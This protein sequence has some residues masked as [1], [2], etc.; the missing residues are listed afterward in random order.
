M[1]CIENEK[2]RGY[3]DSVKFE[4]GSGAMIYIPY[5]IDWFR[6]SKD[7]QTHQA[8]LRFSQKFGRLQCRYYWW[9]EFMIYAVEMASCGMIYLPSFM[10]IGTGVQAILKF[11]IRKL[12]ICNVG[13]TDGR[14]YEVRHWDGLR[15][16]DIHTKFHTDWFRLSKVNRH[17]YADS[18]VIL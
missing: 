17:R 8:I 10:K 15:W 1:D 4:M 6:H 13:I 2:I 9:K 18:K 3:T 14:D 5:F 12:K 16:H 11:W 7:T